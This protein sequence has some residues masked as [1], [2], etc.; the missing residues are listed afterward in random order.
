MCQGHQH[1]EEPRP[2]AVAVMNELAD[3]ISLLP[4]NAALPPSRTGDPD[5][6]VRIC[7]G[8]LDSLFQDPVAEIGLPGANSTP[9]PTPTASPPQLPRGPATNQQI[10]TLVASTRG[11]RR[12]PAEPGRGDAGASGTRSQELARRAKR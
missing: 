10:A 2:S 5:F 7:P 8:C 12:R 9:T 3:E 11:I 6:Q 1:K 4:E